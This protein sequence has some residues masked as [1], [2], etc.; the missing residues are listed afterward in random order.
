M[1]SQEGQ[2]GTFD[3]FMQAP[4]TLEVAKANSHGTGA[5]GLWTYHKR[6]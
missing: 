2:E 1:D 3:R 4:L 6:I 5:N